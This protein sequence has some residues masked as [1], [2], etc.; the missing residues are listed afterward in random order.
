MEKGLQDSVP[1]L[2]G[3]WVEFGSIL[4]PFL[5]PKGINKCKEIL[6]KFRQGAGGGFGDHNG[7]T[8]VAMGPIGRPGHPTPRRHVPGALPCGDLGKQSREPQITWFFSVRTKSAADAISWAPLKDPNIGSFR[9]NRVWPLTGNEDPFGPDTPSRH[10]VPRRIAGA[11]PN[12]RGVCVHELGLQIDTFPPR[13]P[14]AK[15]CKA[16]QSNACFTGRP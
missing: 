6:Q 1:N 7:R 12:R 13:Q 11:S 2:G 9:T 8:W 16:L 15:Q 10:G 3:F 14:L 4:A 5:Q